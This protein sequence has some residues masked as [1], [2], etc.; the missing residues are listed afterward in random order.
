MSPAVDSTAVTPVSSCSN[1]VTS[2]EY[3]T[4]TDGSDSA[5]S[6]NTGSSEYCD[7]N[8]CDSSGIDASLQSAASFR[9]SSGEGY[10][11]CRIGSAA[12]LVVTYTSIGT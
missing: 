8:C 9:A 6:R 1:D 11:R 12:M 3:R 4:V 2:H 5:T 7:T 10:G